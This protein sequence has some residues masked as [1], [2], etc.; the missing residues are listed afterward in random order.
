MATP[1]GVDQNQCYWIALYMASELGDILDRLHVD[2]I[3]ALRLGLH[4]A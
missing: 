2:V 4:L 3:M 1:I